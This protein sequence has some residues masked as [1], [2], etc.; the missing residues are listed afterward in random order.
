MSNIEF[1]FEHVV[2]GKR[3]GRHI[4]HDARKAARP[5]SGPL[6]AVQS[7]N[8]ARN[9]PILNQG[10]VGSC[11]GNATTGALGTNPLYPALPANHPVLNE[12]EALKIYSAA[13]VIDGDGPY[14]PNDNGS[15]GPSAAKAAQNAGLIAG[16][17]HYLDI[18]STLQALQL[19]PVI[20]GI[21]WYTSFDTPSSAGLVAITKGATVRGGH[22]VV[23]RSYDES[24]NLLGFDNSWGLGDWT[25]DGSG[26]MSV[27]TFTTLLSQG[28]DTTAFTPLSGPVPTPSPVVGTVRVPG[29]NGHS[30][31]YAHNALVSAGLVPVAVST[32]K[33][34]EVVYGT[35]P[36]AGSEVSEGTKVTILAS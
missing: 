14:P 3:L 25:A 9:I 31:G 23:V 2:P 29:L 35:A 10:N 28:G 19:G 18:N 17:S 7:V 16:F 22:E 24:T 5:F 20:I 32:Q 1:Q 36:K 11:T 15:T 30:A 8:W 21:S 27:D 4:D 33:A 34:T 12:A 6:K 13:E 26:F